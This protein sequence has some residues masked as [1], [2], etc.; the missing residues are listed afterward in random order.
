MKV[1]PS[2]RPAARSPLSHCIA[3]KRATFS[4][5]PAYVNTAPSIVTKVR[6]ELTY[7]L[8]VSSLT[9]LLGHEIIRNS[10][11]MGYCD[12]PSTKKCRSFPDDRDQQGS[13]SL[14][15]FPL[16]MPVQPY[17]QF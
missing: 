10:N 12:C 16:A 9:L 13:R 7:L 2:R 17:A 4:L 11:Y 14:P 6:A 3:A 15:S 8:S 1:V 5:L